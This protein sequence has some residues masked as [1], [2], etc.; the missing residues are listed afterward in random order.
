[1]WITLETRST[2]GSLVDYAKRELAEICPVLPVNVAYL[3]H[4]CTTFSPREC[5]KSKQKAAADRAAAFT[6]KGDNLNEQNFQ[7]Y[8]GSGKFILA[9]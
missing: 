7:I 2:S 3:H 5:D 1:M 6:L 9:C 4:Q 8:K